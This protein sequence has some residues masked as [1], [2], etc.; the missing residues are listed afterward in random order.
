MSEQLAKQFIEKCKKDPNFKKKL[1]QAKNQSEVQAL[2]KENGFSFTH[3]EYKQAAKTVF[4][5]EC[6][7]QEL[8]QITGGQTVQPSFEEK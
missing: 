1:G 8:Q 2:L 6:S 5:K 7:P 3:E 4:G